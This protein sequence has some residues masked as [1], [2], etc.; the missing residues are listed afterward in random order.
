[1][2]KK[3]LKRGMNSHK[4][5]EIEVSLRTSSPLATT[6]ELRL[7][8]SSTTLRTSLRLIDNALQTYK[9]YT[10]IY[11]IIIISMGVIIIL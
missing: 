5:R 3:Q 7:G 1:M 11:N 10:N 9:E 8:M 6:I 2:N 4:N